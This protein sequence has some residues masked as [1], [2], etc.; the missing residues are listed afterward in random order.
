MTAM[1]KR[2]RNSWRRAAAALFA[3]V[4]VASACEAAPQPRETSD[5]ANAHELANDAAYLLLRLSAYDYALAGTLTGARTHIVSIPRYSSVVRDSAAN[6]QRFTG[7]ALGATLDAS[8]PLRDR[9]VTLAD[10]LVDVSRSATRYADGG[11]PAAFAEVVSGVRQSWKDLD[12]LAKLV[13]PAD[14]ELLATIQRGASFV[15]AATPGK[16]YALTVG[17]F[18]SSTEAGD[19]AR[20]IG[21]VESVSTESPFVVRVG[22]YTD[23]AAGQAQVTSLS[24]KGFTG[25]LSE[26]ERY[27]FARTGPT[28]DAELWREP[29]RVFDTWGGARRVAVAPNAEYVVTGSDDGTV[30]VFS[31]NGTLRSLPRFF[32][33][34][35]HLV[36][37]DDGKWAM[38]GGITLVNFALPQGV[39]VGVPVRLETPAT[40]VVYVPGANY[41]AAIAK[42]DG[43]AGVIA[44]RAPDGV[45][46]T[47]IFPI[48]LPESGGALAANAAGELY[49]AW[50]D[51]G[52][53]ELDVLNMA[54]DRQKHGVMKVP[55]TVSE[56]VVTRDGAHGA[57]MTDQGVYSFGP[58]APNPSAT[59]KRVGDPVRQIAIGA[60]G[61][62]YLMTQ[63]KI[64]ALDPRGEVAWT[65]AL[66]DGRRLVIADRP[67]VL[68]GADR[69]LT[70][71]KGGIAEDL[72]TSGTIQD[73]AA[74]PDGKR[75][76]VLADSSRAQIFKLP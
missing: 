49:W 1:T 56:L 10:S 9:V 76:A 23:K 53:T 27:R 41:F 39:G 70:F 15:V 62:L 34:V 21:T 11:D 2:T 24:V 58:H 20:R 60:D 59:L 55:G 40:E 29:A 44:G 47:P 66:V 33:G 18:A 54:G 50:S 52:T 61:T 8:G 74:S 48:S 13:R 73:V 32:A 71:T 65:S 30:A 35:A 67:I 72:G 19:A 43:G 45:P 46:L 69:L 16:I 31:G 75:I 3:L 17:P 63:T 57:V 4:L 5:V 25:V 38:G 36:F 6:I 51:S 26:E 42:G 12:A 14:P 68:D 22:T 7:N 64:T 28:P 37:S